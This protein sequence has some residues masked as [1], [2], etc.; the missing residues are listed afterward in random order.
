MSSTSASEFAS[1]LT[2]APRAATHSGLIEWIRA[3][4]VAYRRWRERRA[5]AAALNALDGH[6]LRDIGIDRSEVMSLVYGRG[7]DVTR[8]SRV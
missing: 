4:T 5:A 3:R 8:R 1:G 2:G 7:T 6:L